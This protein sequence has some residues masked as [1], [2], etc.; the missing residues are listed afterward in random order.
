MQNQ[1]HRMQEM[2]IPMDTAQAETGELPALQ[3]TPGHAV[4]SQGR[5]LM[6]AICPMCDALADISNDTG[7]C[8]RCSGED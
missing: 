2:Q 5:I 3:D 4:R 1:E 7:L 8:F 6:R